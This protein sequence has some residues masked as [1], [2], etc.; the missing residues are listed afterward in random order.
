MNVDTL[1]ERAEA[2]DRLNGTP[3]AEVRWHHER[4]ELL[5][6]ITELEARSMPDG[7]L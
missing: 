1:R 7:G 5:A 6:R 2:L 4:E 3:C